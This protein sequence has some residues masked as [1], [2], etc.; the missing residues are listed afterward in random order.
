MIIHNLNPIIVKLGFVQIRWYSLFY[1]IGLTIAYFMIRYLAK[2]KKIKLTKDD[3]LDYIV[4][5]AVG[6]LV[7]ARLFYFIFYDFS[8]LF[9]NP[10]ELFKLWHGGMSFHGGLIG[11]LT[12]G[13]IF[14]KQKKIDWRILADLTVVPLGLALAL[15]RLGNFINGELY[16]R[17]WDGAL[18]IDYTQNRH[19]NNLPEFCRYPSQL[20]ESFKN[21]IIFSVLWTIRDKKLPKGFLFYS[22]VLMYGVMR[23]FIEF[24]REPDSQLGFIYLNFTMGQVLC[25]FMILFGGFM[26]IKSKKGK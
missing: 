16:G 6:L 4:Y 11:A 20:I 17:V 26:I 5:L 2:K 10:L 19:L 1:I 23:F 22:F 7:G 13:F 8:A 14:S 3:V 25:F 21:V 9:K 18:C 15:G 12:A 24:I